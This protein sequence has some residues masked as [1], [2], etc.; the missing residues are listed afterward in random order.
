MSTSALFA[1]VLRTELSGIIEISDAQIQ[2]LFAHYEL[3]VR[4]NRRLNLTTVIDLPEAAYRHYCES[5]FVGAH[6]TGKTVVD[7]GTG[8]GFPGIPIAIARPEWSVTL[9]EAHKR[10]AVFLREATRDIPNVSVFE[11]RAEALRGDY[12]WLVSRAV[13]M[14]AISRVRLARRFAVLMGAADAASMAE[15]RIVPVPWGSRRFLA[16]GAA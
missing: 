3:L 9:V 14:E 1:E 8:A 5:L 10:K 15:A 2:R 12:D 6:I 4:W 7:I 13:S 11:G 16:I